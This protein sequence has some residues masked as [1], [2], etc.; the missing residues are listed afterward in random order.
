MPTDLDQILRSIELIPQKF[1]QRLVGID[2]LGASGKTTIVDGIKRLHAEISIIR[3]EDFYLP[4]M[5]RTTG[6]LE[7]HGMPHL[8]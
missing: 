7:N 8:N 3:L 1:F 2:G 4:K 6:I 5:N